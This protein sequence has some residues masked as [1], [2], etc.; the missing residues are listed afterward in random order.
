MHTLLSFLSLGLVLLGALL[1]LRLLPR[2]RSW[3]LRRSMQLFTLALPLVSIGLGI[4]GL[5]HLITSLCPFITPMWDTLFGVM[6]PL[7]MGIVVLGALCLGV[8]RLALMTYVVTRYRPWKSPQLQEHVD[9]LAHQSHTKK[10]RILLCTRERPLAF[11]FGVLRP[12]ILLSTWMVTQLDRR[13]LE[14]VLTHELEHVARRDYLAVWFATV[15][16]D[17]FF[18]LPTSR[19]AY[20]Q[21]QQEKEFACDEMAVEVTHRPLALASAL[22]KVWLHA[23]EEP[24]LVRIGKAQALVEPKTLITGRIE[25]LLTSCSSKTP[26]QSS[27]GVSFALNALIVTILFALQAVNMIV[28]FSLMGCNPLA[29]L[30]RL[31]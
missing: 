21:L 1:I 28:M 13:E 6:L 20:H 30:L 19:V 14:A 24:Q 22:T 7:A 26:L 4:D 25:R 5:H 17:A 12:T 9:S 16:R 23:V 18:Y 3:S 10:A 11:T 27:C 15:L 8:I 31:F 29:L 2:V